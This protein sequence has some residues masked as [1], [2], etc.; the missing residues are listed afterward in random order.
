METS[1]YFV[2]IS[3]AR[4]PVPRKFFVLFLPSTRGSAMTEIDPFQS[5]VYEIERGIEMM[6]MAT[7]PDQ[8]RIDR[9]T[10]A[11]VKLREQI[12]QDKARQAS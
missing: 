11:L 3:D 7:P 4:A 12:A 5:A 1:P 9:W 2:A 6:K 8:D 10:V